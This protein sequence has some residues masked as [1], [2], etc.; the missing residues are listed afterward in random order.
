MIKSTLFA[1]TFFTHM[2]GCEGHARP[3]FV[4]WDFSKDHEVSRLSHGKWLQS[5]HKTYRVDNYD[6]LDISI[7]LRHEQEYVFND[8]RRVTVKRQ[9]ANIGSIHISGRGLSKANAMKQL[10]AMHN[11]WQGDGAKNLQEWDSATNKGSLKG[12]VSILADADG[13]DKPTIRAE[14]RY[15]FGDRDDEWFIITS[16]YWR[17]DDAVESRSTSADQVI[18]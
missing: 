14:I 16:F 9:E 6:D 17:H 18:P 15:N 2:L 5:A 11:K 4:K 8:V 13:T 3:L 12:F 7:I 10:S 1:L